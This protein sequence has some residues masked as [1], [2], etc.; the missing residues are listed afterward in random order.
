MNRSARVNRSWTGALGWLGAA[1]VGVGCGGGGGNDTAAV[2]EDSPGASAAVAAAATRPR[3][4]EMP[5]KWEDITEGAFRRYVDTT[6]QFTAIGDTNVVR[7]CD[8]PA[9]CNA[10]NGRTTLDITPAQ[11][12]DGIDPADLHENGH[13]VAM[14]V[15][16]GTGKERKYK[17][18]ANVPKVY[19]LVTA[20]KSRFVWFDAAGNRHAVGDS[21]FS[22]CKPHEAD[23]SGRKAGFRPCPSPGPD[24]GSV[25]GSRGPKGGVPNPDDPSWISCVPGCCVAAQAI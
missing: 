2:R 11:D 20:G 13:V 19:W 22:G 14:L 25:G 8:P 7:D 16:R 17:I 3:T 12:T 9:S 1:M 23:A 10:N 5:A 6:L 4:P 21:P 15:N 24:T 18:P